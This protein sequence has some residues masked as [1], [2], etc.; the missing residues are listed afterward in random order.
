[1]LYYGKHLRPVVLFM[2]SSGEHASKSI[3]GEHASNIQ[4]ESS[5]TVQLEGSYTTI[6]GLKRS[7]EKSTKHPKFWKGSTGKSSRRINESLVNQ[8]R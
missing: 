1:M 3:S 4:G 6:N 2:L 7:K 5:V 8:L